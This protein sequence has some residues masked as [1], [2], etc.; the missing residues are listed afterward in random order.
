MPTVVQRRLPIGAEV[1]GP[2]GV[3]FR[4]WAPDRKQIEVVVDGVRTTRLKAEGDGYF[5]GI[6]ELARTRS[7]YE[8]R[9]D[10]MPRHYPDPASRFQPIGPHGPSQV[11]DPNSFPWT[12]HEWRGIRIE[13]QI[14]Y[15][16]H[17]GTF[18]EEGTWSAAETYLPELAE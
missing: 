7:L 3:H 8:F 6:D 1:L 4:V 2:R 9:L 15:E 18:T 11:V 17:I 12:D 14:I 16:I 10:G 5:S 13:G